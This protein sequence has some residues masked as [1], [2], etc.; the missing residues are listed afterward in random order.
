M[1]LT[2][3]QIKKLLEWFMNDSETNKKWYEK[4]INISKENHQWIQ[5]NLITKISDEEL[6]EKF[7]EYFN[8]VR[9]GDVSF[10]LF[11]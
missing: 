5:P 9:Q 7:L 3:D 8:R 4:R 1:S 6:K 10:V 2:E 11:I